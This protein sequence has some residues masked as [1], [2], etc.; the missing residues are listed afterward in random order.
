MKK[1]ASIICVVWVAF[2]AVVLA[3]P[4]P[5]LE[6]RLAWPRLTA[7]RPLWMEEAPDRSDRF[8]IVEQKGR[9]VVVQKGADGSESKEFLN[10]VARKPF[11]EMQ[12]LAEACAKTHWQVH[13]ACP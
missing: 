4:L 3:Q 10:I 7:D 12:T 6:M 8:F 1:F 5:K 2:A 11:V 13:A 9:V